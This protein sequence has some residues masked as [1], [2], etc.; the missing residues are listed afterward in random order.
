MQLSEHLIHTGDEQKFLWR[1][2]AMAGQPVD[3]GDHLIVNAESAKP[4]R[5]LPGASIHIIMKR[6]AVR[7]GV[8]EQEARE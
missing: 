6:R 8:I 7:T 5:A 2:S 1:V 3:D 4:S